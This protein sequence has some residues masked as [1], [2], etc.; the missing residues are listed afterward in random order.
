MPAP[1]QIGD[2]LTQLIAR[3]GYAREISTA[4]IE[5]VW[6]AAVGEKIAKFTR[7]GNIRRGTLEVVV[8]NNLLVQELG[9]QKDQVL[10]KLQIS[11]PQENIKN[12][13]FRVGSVA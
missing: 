12:L 8:A 10:K 5:R 7:P 6:A 3:R 11:A 4:E 2:V 13:R 9:F 1:R